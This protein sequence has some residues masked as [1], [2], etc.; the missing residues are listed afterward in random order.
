MIAESS[1]EDFKT[2]FSNYKKYFPTE[3]NLEESPEVFQKNSFILLS[4]LEIKKQE[5][6][7]LLLES[8][9]KS[10]QHLLDLQELEKELEKTQ[11]SIQLQVFDTFKK[12][13][14][15]LGFILG[16]FLLARF[17]VHIV[18]KNAN[19]SDEKKKVIQSLIYL[20]RNIIIIAI[21]IVFF[22]SELLNFLPFLAILGTAI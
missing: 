3:Q 5:L 20:V 14:S 1:L 17:G 6:Q 19:S 13:A 11:L 22:F 4:N 9:Q 2:F 10:K 8:E 21:V 12:I 7:K 16:T 15:F 18:Q